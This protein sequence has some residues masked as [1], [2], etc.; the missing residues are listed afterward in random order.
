MLEGMAHYADQ[1]L[2]PADGFGR[3]L[4]VIMLFLPILGHFW[5]SLVTLVT[6][7]SEL[8]NFWG[9]N[10]CIYHNKNTKK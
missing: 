7:S 5:C 6:F 1:H 3:G 4:F 2:A 10:I 9:K 8:D